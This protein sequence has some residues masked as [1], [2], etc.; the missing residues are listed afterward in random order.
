MTVERIKPPALP[1]KA[2]IAVVAPASPPQTRSE[3]EQATAYFEALGHEVVLGP[4]HRKVHGYL[5]GTDAERAAD[6]QWAL[7]EPGIDMVHTLCGGY[8]CARLH[9]LDRLGRARRAADRVRLLRHHGA[10]PRA[11]GTRGLGDV[12]RAELLS[13]HAGAARS[14]RRRRR[15]GSIGR[16][17]PSR[18]GRCSRTRRTPTCSPSAAA[19][20]EAPLV[21]GC[22]TL[23]CASIGTPFEVETD[24]CVLM[25]EDLFTDE[26][27]V[28]TLLNHLIR[29]GKF[30]NVD[31]LRLR[32]ERQPVRSRAAGGPESMLSIEEML[33]ELIGPLGIPAVAN[34]PGRPRQAH[35]D[36]AARGAR[37]ARR[38]QEGARSDGGGCSMRA[39]GMLMAAMAAL[40][41]SAAAILRSRR[42]PRTRRAPSGGESV[43]RIGWSQDPKTLNPFVGVNE[44]EFTIWAINWELLVGFEP[45]GPLAGAGDRGELGRLR[46]RHDLHLQPDRGR[47][48]VRRR[49]DHLRG[50][51][52]VARE[53]R[54]EQPA[55]HRLHERRRVDQDARRAH[56]RPRDEA[57]QRPADRRPLRLH[58]PGAHL[59]RGAGRRPRRRLPA[60]GAAGRERPVHRHRVRAEPDPD[61][62]A[63]PG[64]AGRG[65]CASTSSSSSATAAPTRSSAPSPS[66]RSTSSP[67]SSRRR[68]TAS[69]SRRGSRR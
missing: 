21:G 39:R 11:R 17:S 4:N 55:L 15:S 35:G 69:A 45:G 10:P 43:L 31:G 19:Q 42:W 64:V 7:S 8:G 46:G 27:L 41:R 20:A 14:S 66:A 6:L 38:G 51:Q 22:L 62:G 40:M 68:S 3:T 36:D 52:V 44:E 47:E 65:A 48:V 49:A 30:D 33:D 16:S 2:R 1:D 58:P 56:G 12:L 25:V 34:V 5:A 18:S 37:A 9:D 59:G 29:A 67:R 28:D 53:P 32:H 63:E 54:R 61:H 24:G 26:Y 13:L 50:R 57:A 23:L 60:R